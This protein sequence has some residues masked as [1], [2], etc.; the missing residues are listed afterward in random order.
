MILNDYWL[1]HFTFVYVKVWAAFHVTGALARPKF[2]KDAETIIKVVAAA[3]LAFFDIAMCERYYVLFSGNVL[4]VCVLLQY[5]ACLFLYRCRKS[6]MFLVISYLW[7]GI[8]LMDLFLQTILY[9]IQRGIYGIYGI[10]GWGERLLQPEDERGLYLLIFSGGIILVACRLSRW[11]KT[12][13]G[14]FPEEGKVFYILLLPFS[15]CMMYFQRIYLWN[16]SKEV[17]NHWWIF[18]LGMTVAILLSL[19]YQFRRTQ[20][21][22]YLLQQQKL[23][24]L[25]DN[26]RSLMQAYEQKSI[27]LHDLNKHMNT[28]REIALTDKED[29]GTEQRRLLDV[30]EHMKESWK[31]NRQQDFCNHGLLNL[32]LNQ[33]REA[34]ARSGIEMTYEFDDMHGLSMADTDICALFVNLLD[35]AIEANERLEE[36]M[37]R[38][39]RLSGY[40][41]GAQLILLLENPVTETEKE[42]QRK[43]WGTSKKNTELHGF[44]M[45]SIRQV[46]G[47]YEGHMEIWVQDGTFTLSA[48]LCAYG[49]RG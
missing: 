3:G 22:K 27:L 24:L 12:Q 33:K 45:K 38:W 4:L 19:F 34:A 20:E 46:I 40:R 13:R 21:N 41:K 11:I 31:R 26:Y 28:I 6:I 5:I 39:V 18:I 25:S 15:V 32:I 8:T 35:N 16:P 43:L 14:A 7:L 1:C 48:F 49:L 10:Y 36:G 2:S 23:E 37:E 9:E 29:I 42:V 30:A 17:M 47:A 44:G